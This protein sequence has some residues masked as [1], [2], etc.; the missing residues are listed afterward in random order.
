M[1]L[2]LAGAAA[3]LAI[4]A[5]I[6]FLLAAFGPGEKK[7]QVRINGQL[8]T[9]TQIQNKAISRGEMRG[10]PLP[11]GNRTTLDTVLGGPPDKILKGPTPFSG[12]ATITSSKGS[13]TAVLIGTAEPGPGGRGVRSNGRAEFTGGSG[14]FKNARGSGRFSDDR[15]GDPRGR[16]G[17]LTVRGSF[18]SEG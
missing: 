15:T 6:I 5:I 11:A 12:K 4:A 16:K 18:T 17:V 1:G 7:R 13:L 3:L 9:V 10:R 14:D 2:V 8:Q